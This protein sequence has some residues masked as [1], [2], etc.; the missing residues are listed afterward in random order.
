MPGL[1]RVPHMDQRNHEYPIEVPTVRGLVSSAARSLGL[2]RRRSWRQWMYFDQGAAP[3]CTAYGSATFLA[4]A[5][6]KPHM[7]W[8]R[9]LDVMAWYKENTAEDRSH[10]RFFD[11]GATTLAAME[12]GKRRGYWDEYRWTYDL[13]V[14]RTT[15]HDR[16]PV[17][18]GTNWYESM[19]RR[20]PEGVVTVPFPGERPAGGHLYTIGAYDPKRALYVYRSTWGDGDY[21]IPEEL[22]A[23]LLA[24][25]GECVQPHEIKVGT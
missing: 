22:M 9:M 19:W 20:S 8:L 25:D 13:G 24:E 11:G 5:P 3:A 10:G 15:V 12:V 1:G 7:P 23:R 21:L 2:W 18:V 14:L 6:L 17:I 16:Q 4:A